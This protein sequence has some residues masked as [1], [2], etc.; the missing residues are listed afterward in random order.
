MTTD[1]ARE[2][3]GVREGA[4]SSEIEQAW[5]NWI[6]IRHLVQDKER[7]K[8]RNEAYET[9]KGKSEPTPQQASSKDSASMHFQENL[10]KDVPPPDPTSPEWY[11]AENDYLIYAYIEL[12][13]PHRCY[14]R[15]T[16]QSRAS[17]KEIEI[18]G[19]GRAALLTSMRLCY[20]KSFME[21]KTLTTCCATKSLKSS[22]ARPTSARRKRTNISKEKTQ[23]RTAGIF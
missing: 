7:V 1:K 14:V 3:L 23:L 19:K 4:S 21:R 18:I 6:S 16:L 20:T 12:D 22:E 15:Q 17:H 11:T 9:L 8:Q 13:H 10:I 2:I 5:S